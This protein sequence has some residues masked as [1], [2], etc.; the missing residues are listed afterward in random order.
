[1]KKIITFIVLVISLAGKAQGVTISTTKTPLQLVN[2]VLISA[3]CFQAFNV[4]ASTGSTAP[5]GSTNGIGYFENIDPSNPVTPAVPFNSN[6]PF[7]SGVVIST[8]DVTKVPSP[9]NTLQSNG[10]VAWPGDSDLEV[11]LAAQ[12][13][14]INS[15]NATKLQFEFLAKQTTFDLSF[16]FA[17]EEYGEF[18]CNFSDAFAFLIK[19]IT[20]GFESPYVNVATVP[21]NAAPNTPITVATIRDAT[22]NPNCSS[23][24]SQFFGAYNGSGFGPAINFNGQT[25][26]MIASAQLIFN[27]TY[28]VKLVVADGNNNV[29]SDSAI[30]LQAKS[31]NIGGQV[32]GLDY[33]ATNAGAGRPGLCIGS[34]HPSL[35]P[36]VALEA[37]TTYVWQKLVGGQYATLAGFNGSSYDLNTVFPPALSYLNLGP[38]TNTYRLTY[39]TPGCA[40]IQDPIT[41]FLYP[42][43]NSL[44]VVPNL[45]K[46]I[47]PTATGYTYD[48]TKTTAIILENNTPADPFDNLNGVTITY[49]TSVTNA[50]N[51]IAVGNSITITAAQAQAGYDMWAKIKNNNS[52]C[53]EIRN[54]KLTLVPP[55]TIVAPPI[56]LTTCGD[57]PSPAPRANFD[58]NPN[59]ALILGTQDPTL[60]SFSF[61]NSQNGANTSST[62]DFIFVPITNIKNTTSDEIFVRLQNKLDPTCFVTTSFTVTVTP[63]AY[64]DILPDVIVCNSFVL[65]ALTQVGAQYWSLTNGTGTQYFAGDT[66]TPVAATPTTIYV[67]NSNGTCFTNDAFKITKASVTGTTSIAPPSASFCGQTTLP[68]LAYGVYYKNAG[69]PNANP[70]GPAQTLVNTTGPNNFYVWFESPTESCTQ[71]KPFTITI[72]TLADLPTYNDVFACSSYIL[73][74]AGNGATYYNGPGKTLGAIATGTSITSSKTIYVYKE[75]GTTPNCFTETSFDVTIGLANNTDPMTDVDSCAP[76]A[77]PTLA[78][79]QYCAGAN[80]ASPYAANAVISGIGQTTVYYFI[81]GQSCTNNKSFKVNVSLLPLDPIADVVVCDVFT[82]PVVPGRPN[83]K[84]YT[85]DQPSG[86]FRTQGE[87]I[88]TVGAQTYYFIDKAVSGPC[89]VKEEFL[90][91]I[92]ATPDISERPPV[93]QRCNQAFV[94]DDLT[95]GEYYKNAGG[96]SSSNPVLAPLTSFTT[97]DPGQDYKEIFVYAGSSVVGNTCNREYS[98]KVY[99]V[100]T[101]VDPIANVTACDTYPLPALPVGDYYTMS[102]GPLVTGNQKIIL[103]KNIT[104]TTTLYAYAENNN[105]LPCSD[106]ETFT[107]T[108]V[109][110]PDL[111][112]LAPKSVCDSY[113]VP[114][115]TDA[116]FTFTSTNPGVVTKFYKNPGGTTANPLATDVYMPGQVITNTNADFSPL[117]VTLYPYAEA[118]GTG[119]TCFDDEPFVVTINRTPVIVPADVD[120]VT[121]CDTYALP[122]L[123]IGKYYSAATH[124][125]SEELA[126]GYAITDT[127]APTTVYV[128]AETLTTP[129]CF[130]TVEDFVVTI[131]ATPV[132]SAIA[133]VSSCDTYTVPQYADAMF[134]STN[135]IT[136]FYKNAGGPANNPLPSDEYAEG[137]E[138]I[139]TGTTPLIV[140]IYAYSAVGSVPCFDDEPFIVTIDKSPVI[141]PA[142]VVAVTS[143]DS[144]A[145]L[146]L[147]VG[148]YYSAPTHLPSEELAVGFAITD[149]TAPTTIYVYAENPANPNCTASASFDVTIVTTPV[150]DPIAPVF[151]CD[152]YTIPAYSNPMF[153]STNPITKFYKNAG[154]PANN[155]LPSDQYLPAQVI[156]YAGVANA[157]D[158]FTVYAYSAVGSVPCWDDQPFVVTINK[159]PVIVASEVVAITKCDS[160]TLP[161]LTVGTYVTSTGAP[162][163]N[164]TITTTQTVYVRAINGVAP[165]TCVDNKNFL[166][167]I[168]KTPQFTPAEVAD[169]S[170]CNAYI[171]PTLSVAGA[172]YYTAPNGPS[173]GGTEIVLPQSYTSDATVYAYAET[174]TLPNCAVSESIN[175]QV[176]N[177][178][179]L[180]DVVRCGSYTLPA[181]SNPNV[182]YYNSPGQVGLIPAGTVITVSQPV[183]VVGTSP[184]GCFDESDFVVTINGEP[185]A[186]DVAQSVCDTDSSPY[187]GIT[188]YDLTTLIPTILGTTQLPTDFT[189]TFY[190]DFNRQ[191]VINNP[192]QC[193]LPIVYVFV[194]NNASTT[195]PSPAVININVIPLPNPKLDVAPICIDSETGIVTNSVIESGYN[196]LDYTIVWTMASD[197]TV[198]SNDQ[199]FSTDVPGDYILNVTSNDVT[200]CVSGNVPF[201]VIQSAK[202]AVT[203]PI[204]FEITGWFTNYQ[205]ITVN[206]TPYVGDGS[207]FVYSLDGD[208]PQVSNIFKNVGIGA[209]EIT[210]IDINGCGSRALPIPVT[211][212][213]SPAAFTPNGDGINDKWNIEG[214][215]LYSTLTIYDR[216]GRLLKQLTQKNNGWDGTINNQA[217]PADDYWFTLN[218]I[219]SAGTPREYKSHFSLIR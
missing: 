88:Y 64:V 58:F 55:P 142:E 150:I 24:N 104:T 15:V 202:P 46:C 176:Y 186:N 33:I 183:Y 161:A 103:P 4:S 189:V 94:L 57:A 120:D 143:C 18:Q 190:S 203:P 117:V 107:V 116:M 148:K 86:Q 162:L 188:P 85:T 84:Y 106:E 123:T 131:V 155:P 48:L 214:D 2:E 80:G 180:A 90:L 77:L 34:T 139:N 67:F 172:K 192:A 174:G 82:F 177:V 140:T 28:R 185:I 119:V 19:D 215:I 83:G 40:D 93:V 13:V 75:T 179:E 1:M 127:T 51:N 8:G 195:C 133:P 160:Y 158:V 63:L 73:P 209:H 175:I 208:T 153:T 110:T 121:A 182:S 112:A 7:T 79:G 102:G 35:Q 68:A 130:A 81:P 9:N 14:T 105:R 204:S 163:G 132:V 56:N 20:P 184:S 141:V 181:L 89:F 6:F 78:F 27:H 128:Y 219:D 205:T 154:G 135:P 213:N 50:E 199:S 210:V 193:T 3:P 156:L 16:I 59:L 166:V 144:Y 216:F 136:K 45:N 126:V 113:I 74:A 72:I 92:N 134:T 198:V 196:S 65:P 201:T 42:A 29:G 187:D 157:P 17:S 122:V 47:N 145:L 36:T 53:Y 61:H 23:V 178:V 171:L 151:G 146:P 60:Y 87:T 26:P 97:N 32:L 49:H 152:S 96:L 69:G 31:L 170:T 200:T 12:G 159:S 99:F 21:A 30:F 164:L 125:A 109:K 52:G 62:T 100:N 91:T 43:I 71:E 111:I 38:G 101:S 25:V 191:V 11:A 118:L 167:T 211:L 98:I 5:F 39:K 138:I 95:F 149:T 129:N 76:Y 168:N 217:L 137:Q 147:T 212:V 22:Y 207:N 115:Y 169:V 114:S 108:I 41:V 10:T 206:A 66:I 37:G 124:L 197:G 218:Y 173:G 54:F 165:N 194:T 44:A 70:G